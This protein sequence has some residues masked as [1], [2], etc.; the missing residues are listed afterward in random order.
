MIQKPDCMLKSPGKLL[1]I[2]IFTLY[3]YILMFIFKKHWC[4]V[5]LPV[6]RGSYLISLVWVL[7]IR[8]L[9]CFPG[10]FDMH[11][12]LRTTEITNACKYHL[13]A[14]LLIDFQ[15]ILSWDCLGKNPTLL[16][17][18]LWLPASSFNYQDFCTP[19]WKSKVI[20]V[21]N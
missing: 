8:V 18:R 13:N 4:Q 21:P 14:W 9:K 1:K 7:G 6:P 15:Q 5:L 3:L 10:E 11:P 17:I 16:F 19:F 2:L 12:R 20:S